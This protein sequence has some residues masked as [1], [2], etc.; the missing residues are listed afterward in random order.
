MISLFDK[1][2]ALTK[3]N[4]FIFSNSSVAIIIHVHVMLYNH[5][6]INISFSFNSISNVNNRMLK[7]FVL[8]YKIWI[9]ESFI[10]NNLLH[11]HTYLHMI[12]SCSSFFVHFLFIFLYLHA[13]TEQTL[14][15]THVHVIDKNHS[16]IDTY[17]FI[18][19]YN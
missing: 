3:T 4:L 19:A 5:Q 18:S 10:K 17:F 2:T 1:H 7:K 14:R 12:A 11:R 6:M 13:Q 15:R 8:L 9:F 16:C